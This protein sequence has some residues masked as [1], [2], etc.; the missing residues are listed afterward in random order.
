[1]GPVMIDLRRRSNGHQ[2]FALARH[3]HLLKFVCKCQNIAYGK[4]IWDH[5]VF[6]LGNDMV[7][8]YIMIYVFQYIVYSGHTPEIV[9]GL[10]CVF[11]GFRRTSS[12]LFFCG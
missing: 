12:V 7:S 5:S 2:R 6:R 3:P 10:H 11:V 9:F 1:M 4:R 8:E